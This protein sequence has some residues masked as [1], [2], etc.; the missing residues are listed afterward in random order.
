MWTRSKRTWI[1]DRVARVR[2]ARR[3]QGHDLTRLQQGIVEAVA[4]ADPAYEPSCRDQLDAVRA[5]VAAHGVWRQQTEW[6]IST[7]F[8]SVIR[9][10]PS[11][12]T[13]YEVVVECDGQRLSCRC[14]SLEGAY[15]FMRLYEAIIID[16]F[17][18]VGPPWAAT[19]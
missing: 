12:A 10:S 7:C 5:D 8:D 13:L 16:Q 1:A 17:Y 4:A 19:S 11:A 2:A 9:V 3:R 15:S 14:P 6:R 18:S